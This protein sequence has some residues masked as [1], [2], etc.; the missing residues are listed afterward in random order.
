MGRTERVEEDVKRVKLMMP[1]R[2]GQ[3]QLLYTA[4]YKCFTQNSGIP[5]IGIDNNTLI[6]YYLLAVNYWR[7]INHEDF[8][9]LGAFP[10]GCFLAGADQSRV[11]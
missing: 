6:F 2:L 3:E 8:E 9:P 7:Q 4:D 11:W 5:K 10:R 1:R